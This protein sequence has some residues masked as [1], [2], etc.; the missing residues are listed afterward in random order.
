MTHPYTTLVTTDVLAAHLGNPDWA[1]IDCRFSLA[2]AAK[3][4]RDYLAAHI[5]GAVYAHLDESLSSPQRPGKSGRHPLPAPETFA[6]QVAAWG[7]DDRVQVVVYDDAGA[8]VSGRVWWMLRWLGHNAVAVLDGDWRAWL[9]EGR[10]TRGG[11]E[12]RTPRPFVPALQPGLTIDTEEIAARLYDPALRLF[13]A[14]SAERYRG[15]NETI[16]PRAGHIPGALS[17]PFTDNLTGDGHFLPKT[18]L[19]VRWEARRRA[20]EGAEIA[21]YCGSGV[22]AAHHVLA[23]AH[24]GLPLP[25]LYVGSWSE[26]IADPARPAATG[27]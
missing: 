10:P 21:V 8:M 13:D 3:G 2:D 23:H 19:R 14:R 5:P 6:A 11:I 9:A 7:I 16:D 20:A 12:T 24:A 25:R 18:D 15:E 22:S 17:A 4:R 27:A 1:V 26:W